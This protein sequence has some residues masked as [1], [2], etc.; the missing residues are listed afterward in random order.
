MKLIHL[1][2]TAVACI[3]FAL[4]VSG[5]KAAI[6][7]FTTCTT[8]TGKEYY[9]AEWTSEIPIAGELSGMICGSTELALSQKKAAL[10]RENQKAIFAPA[11]VKGAAK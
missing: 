10:L 3:P 6:P 2:I 1:A 11:T 9:C 7:D 8:P 5:C 4:V